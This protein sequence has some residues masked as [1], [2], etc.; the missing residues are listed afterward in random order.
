MDFFGTLDVA[1]GNADTH[2]GAYG[3]FRIGYNLDNDFGVQKINALT[4]ASPVT[5]DIHRMSMQTMPIIGDL[6]IL[7]TRLTVLSC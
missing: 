7:F 2:I 6:I 5:A 4:D 1:L 3:T